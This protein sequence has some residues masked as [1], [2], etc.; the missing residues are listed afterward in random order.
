[1]GAPKRTSAAGDRTL[2]YDGLV[3]R[4]ADDTETARLV[5][6]QLQTDLQNY[7]SRCR[8]AVDAH[9]VETVQRVGHVILNSALMVGAEQ[10][11]ALAW[12]L[13]TQAREDAMSSPR[14]CRTADACIAAM[15]NLDGEVRALL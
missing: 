1:M 15:E 12:E 11:A 4:V 3:T 6:E 5:L 9:D 7:I 2:D 10:L 13:E 14:L 8:S